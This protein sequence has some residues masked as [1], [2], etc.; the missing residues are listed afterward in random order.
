[1]TYFFTCPSLYYFH[2]F[3]RVFS[4]V[5]HYRL[6][7]LISRVYI[8]FFFSFTLILS[9]HLVI[10]LLSLPPVLSLMVLFFSFCTPL[11]FPSFS[12]SPVHTT[13]H[14]LGLPVHLRSPGNNRF[15]P[16]NA[17]H[18][19]AR[20]SL[21]FYRDHN[22]FRGRSSSFL[23]SCSNRLFATYFHVYVYLMESFSLCI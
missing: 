10:T 14:L 12:P 6:S 18:W 5:V 2:P 3:S 16:P 4:S 23:P 8:F 9:F 21:I 13:H 19:A 22:A 17:T 1:M 11:L 20:N 7:T 15:A